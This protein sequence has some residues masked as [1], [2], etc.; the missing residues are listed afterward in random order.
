[1]EIDEFHQFFL[2]LLEPVEK[3]FEEDEN[4]EAKIAYKYAYG[5]EYI[6]SDLCLVD[7]VDELGHL[8]IVKVELGFSVLLAIHYLHNLLVIV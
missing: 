7:G 4:G 2:V 8:G 3:G 6:L 5:F 1:M